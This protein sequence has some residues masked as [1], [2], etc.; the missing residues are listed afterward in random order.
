MEFWSWCVFLIGAR[1]HFS[2]MLLSFVNLFG[3]FMGSCLLV[4]IV[5]ELCG[6]TW[7]YF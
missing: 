7:L 5:G 1:G 2:Y 4:L 3:V 6:V